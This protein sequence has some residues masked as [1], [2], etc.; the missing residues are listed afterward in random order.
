MAADGSSPPVAELLRIAA[1]GQVFATASLLA[2][3]HAIAR[4][5][6][7]TLPVHRAIIRVVECLMVGAEPLVGPVLDVG[8]G[9][10]HFAGSCLVPSYGAKIDV[11]IDPAV[12]SVREAHNAGVYRMALACGGQ[13]LPFATGSFPTVVSNCVLEHIPPLDET[14]REI[15]RVLAPGGKLIITVPS[16]KFAGS[17][18]WSRTLSAVGFPGAGAAY[19]QWFNRISL[20]FHTYSRDE[21]QGHLNAAGFKVE[22]WA[23]YLLPDVMALFDLSHYYGAPTLLTKRLT[24]RWILWP[25]KWRYLPWERALENALASWG[26]QISV[27]HGSYFFF[28]ARKA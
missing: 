1:D 6:L 5:H 21:W 2:R 12:A 17:L 26:R 23:S 18:F 10:G 28:V 27:P 14:L 8:C 7:S 16:D 19:G 13:A 9:D 4:H 20:H 3:A 24:G 11:G 25:G 22:K 15:H